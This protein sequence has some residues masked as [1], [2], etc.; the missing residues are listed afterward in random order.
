MVANVS[1][2]P[3]CAAARSF[4]WRRAPG[5]A[6]SQRCESKADFCRPAM[7]EARRLSTKW[8]LKNSDISE[9]RAIAHFSRVATARFSPARSSRLTYVGSIPASAA[10]RQPAANAQPL[11]ISGSH[12]LRFYKRKRPSND[13]LRCKRYFVIV[14]RSSRIPSM[15][16]RKCAFQTAIEFTSGNAALCRARTASRARRCRNGAF[17]R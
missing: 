4:P 8:I 15:P 10:L 12:G 3:D 11:D 9:S 7:A 2:S 6:A 5:H 17:G 13:G 1:A 14:P 16:Q